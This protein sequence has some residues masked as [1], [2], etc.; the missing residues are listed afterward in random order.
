MIATPTEAGI[1]VSPSLTPTLEA[2]HMRP[3]TGPDRKRLFLLSLLAVLVGAIISGLGKLLVLLIHLVTNLSFFGRLSLA[4]LNPADNHLGLWV[5]VVP[6]IGGL[7]VGLMARYGVRGIQGHGIPEAMEQVLTNQSRIRPIITV[8][9]PLSAA[10]SIGTGGPFGAEGPVIA[11]GGAFASNVGQLLRITHTER[12]ILLAAGATAGMTAVFGTPLAGIFLAIELLLFEFSPRSI[13][14]VAL[15][16]LTGAAGHHLLFEAGPE[17]AMPTVASPSNLALAAYSAI[18]LVVGLLAVGITKGLH[19]LE[20]AFARLPLPWL[21]HP[22]LGGLAVG[23]AAYVAPRV[24]GVGYSNITGLLSGSWPLQAVFMLGALKLVAWSLSLGSGTSGGT[25]AP[26]LTVGAAA[27]S[28]LGALLLQVWPEVGVVLP[29]AALV[30][31]SALFAGASRALLTSVIFG[32]ELTGQPFA[33]VALLGACTAAYV[34]SYFL[35]DHTIM[36]E[37]MAR[38][39]VHTPYSYEPDALEKLSV[40]QVLRPGGL[41]LSAENTVAEVRE[42]LAQQK[43]SKIPTHFIVVDAEGRF[44]GLISFVEIYAHHADLLAPLHTIVRQHPTPILI[45]DSLRTA[46]S[47]M[48]RANVDV[49]PVV[50]A[51]NRLTVT[52]VL[53]YQEVLAA[54][55]SRLREE[56]TREASI[57]LKNRGV[58]ILLRGQKLLRVDSFRNR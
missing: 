32:I 30:G 26:L 49:L 17:F 58:R 33:L 6:A 9:K 56:E 15:A 37:N 14:P 23:V 20:E 27:G 22:A 54:Y 46:V 13:I 52:G 28:L 5:I 1:P 50:D 18:G 45:T 11:T 2:A 19:W 4:N 51:R 44:Q 35:M 55:R 42:W 25:L 34:V 36:T 47:Q 24:L 10:I 43:A 8:L 57:S 12:K 21:L 16:C 48:A 7:L 40:G 29:L 31:M 38:R 39:G 3:H 53:S 41:T